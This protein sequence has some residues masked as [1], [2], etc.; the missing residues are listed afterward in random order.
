MG[1]RSLRRRLRRRGQGREI[2][3][4]Y[5]AFIRRWD[6]ISVALGV[7]IAP[8]RGMMPASRRGGGATQPSALGGFHSASAPG[9]L[10][11]SPHGADLCA[12]GLLHRV[13]DR[14]AGEGPLHVARASLLETIACSSGPCLSCDAICRHTYDIRLC[15]IVEAASLCSPRGGMVE[16]P[17]SGARHER[18]RFL[19]SRLRRRI[20]ES[21]S[22][23]FAAS[24]IGT[25]ARLVP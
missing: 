4:S 8:G 14:V 15:Q 3:A 17:A 16:G 5:A 23:R 24:V 2:V 6:A 11:A 7:S 20:W 25:M 18:F 9:S 12:G 21:A 13:R 19:G 1:R 10:A 22:R